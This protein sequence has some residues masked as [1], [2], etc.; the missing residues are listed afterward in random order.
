MCHLISMPFS[1]FPLFSSISPFIWHS[2]GHFCPF[3]VQKIAH[4]DITYGVTSV[5]TPLQI[6]MALLDDIACTVLHICFEG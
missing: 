3:I 4:L 6:R 5:R 2:K 1:V